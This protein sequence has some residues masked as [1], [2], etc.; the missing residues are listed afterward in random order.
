MQPTFLRFILC[1]TLALAVP[2][3]AHAAP[4]QDDV[5]T[6]KARELHV[7]A[8]ALFAQGQL[9]RARA[10]FIA[11]WALKKH[12]QIAG[13]LGETELKL[14]MYR[15]AAEHLAFFVSNFPPDKGQDMLAAG[16]KLFQ[17][18]R[19][20][21]GT[22]TVTVDRAGAEVAVDG[23]VIGTAPLQDPVFVDPGPH[24]VEARMGA[25]VATM[26]VDAQPGSTRALALSVKEPPPVTPPKDGLPPPRL[27]KAVLISGGTI[28]GIAI[29]AGTVLAVV[30]SG[31]RSDAA[32]QLATLNQPPPSAACQ[33]LPSTCGAIHSDLQARDT[34]ANASMG[35]FIGG[36]VVG[37]TTLGYALLAPKAR[38]AVSAKLLPALG[39]GQGGVVVK[40][41]W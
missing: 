22:L 17:E 11:A 40:G 9:A 5:M 18:A 8:N 10:A 4:P 7:E 39:V 3:A 16:Q 31:K 14:G 19:A 20:K 25:H 36:G 33:M 30:A 23:K 29:V 28:T 12:W 15:D 1:C 27:N 35:T 2:S 24:T 21:V 41:T 32:T 34:L 37:L 26:Q 6:D 38:P 13:G